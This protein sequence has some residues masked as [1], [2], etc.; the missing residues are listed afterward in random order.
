[1]DWL[2]PLGWLA[3]LLVALVTL[4]GLVTMATRTLDG[5]SPILVLALSAG[6]VVVAIL[7]GTRWSG[8]LSTSYW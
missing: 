7:A 4:G 8:G 5:A 1:M 3:A 2:R 6:F